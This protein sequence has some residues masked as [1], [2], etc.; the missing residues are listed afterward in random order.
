MI[1]LQGD[2]NPLSGLSF[3]VLYFATLHRDILTKTIQCNA[4]PQFFAE[5]KFSVQLKVYSVICS[6]LKQK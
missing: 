5:S 6:H 4:I 2:V 1:F 3:P